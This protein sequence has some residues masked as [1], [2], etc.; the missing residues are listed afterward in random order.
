MVMRYRVLGGT[1][2][3]VSACCLGTMMFGSIGN[4]DRA[5]SIR[6]IH[7]ALGHGINFVDTADMYSAG[8]SSKRPPR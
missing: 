2:I 6:I 3:R 1:G 8:Y 4:S 5:D 7:A